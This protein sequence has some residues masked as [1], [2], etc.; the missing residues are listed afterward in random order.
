LLSRNAALAHH[1]RRLQHRA[2][3][4]LTKMEAVGA[5]MNK[6][7]WYVW[8]VGHQQE[9]YDPE[10]WRQAGRP[11]SGEHIRANRR[12]TRER[13]AAPAAAVKSARRAGGARPA[14]MRSGS[15]APLTARRAAHT[16]AA[17]G[18]SLA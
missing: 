6:L 4:P 13:H 3:R 1:Y 11:P 5:C 15:G 17:A 14:G 10:F 18:G 8:H 9:L 16:R 2:Q 7:L 12:L